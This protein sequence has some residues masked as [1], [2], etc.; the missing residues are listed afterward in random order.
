M[1]KSK[2]SNFLID[3]PFQLGFIFRYLVIILLT[4]IIVL[5]LI[6]AYYWFISNIGEYKLNTLITYV[7]RGYIKDQGKQ[8]Y[9]YDKEKILIIEDMDQSGNIIYKCYKPFD[10]KKYKAGDI[11]ENITKNDLKPQIGSINRTT[12]RFRII[13]F[14]L[15]I[16]GLILIIIISIYSIFFSHRMAGPI[17]RMRISLD[18][19]LQGDY[20]FK[21]NVRK[22]DYFIT[23]VEKLEK[24]RQK[25]ARK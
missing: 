5:A 14:P 2:R 15:I 25:I 3:K 20:D 24:L 7:T 22:T 16:T 1:A 4:I 10:S 21:I 23:I 17:Y 8:I 13:L 11:I 6:A 9:E 18:R 19:M 12:T